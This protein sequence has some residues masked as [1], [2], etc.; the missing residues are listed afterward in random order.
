[1]TTNPNRPTNL[2]ARIPKGTVIRG[3]FPDSPKVAGRTY[4]VEVF[5]MDA[6]YLP[7][8]PWDVRHNVGSV[9]TVTWVGGAGYWHEAAREDVEVFMDH[10]LID[11]PVDMITRER[12]AEAREKA[13][14]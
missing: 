1:M 6:G 11:P 3:T 5:R 2:T 13:D 8:D 14:R 10:G 12:L 4:T 9:A 7:R